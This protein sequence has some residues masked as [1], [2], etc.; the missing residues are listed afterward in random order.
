M[1]EKRANPPR[2]PEW[3]HRRSNHFQFVPENQPLRPQASPPPQMQPRKP[4]PKPHNLVAITPRINVRY[5]PIQHPN[6]PQVAGNRGRAIQGN[7]IA[8]F[9]AVV[10]SSLILFL[11]ANA[12]FRHRGNTVPSSSS[13]SVLSRD[14]NS[15]QADRLI[16][17][18]D[19]FLNK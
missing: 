9:I 13:H 5:I 14:N 19:N 12:V 8:K 2:P 6:P 7:K 18:I 10:F 11:I 3:P 16:R 4:D 1:N 17:A 15:N